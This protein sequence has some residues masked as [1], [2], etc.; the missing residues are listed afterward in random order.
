MVIMKPL[1][2]QDNRRHTMAYLQ[3]VYIGD[4]ADVIQSDAE[5]IIDRIFEDGVGI[6]ELMD[7]MPR[8][9]RDDLD[10][11]IV[12]LIQANWDKKIIGMMQDA[13]ECCVKANAQVGG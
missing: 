2:Q 11:L 4:E 6:H 5:Q 10:N 12:R 7:L 13:A 8:N 9:K 1:K 3:P